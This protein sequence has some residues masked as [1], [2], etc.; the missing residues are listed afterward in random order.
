VNFSPQAQPACMCFWYKTRSFKSTVRSKPILRASLYG[1]R[2]GS[3]P[4]MVS[5]TM[6]RLESFML[7][8]EGEK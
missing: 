3:S 7:K 4:L 1:L 6:R 5:M 2:E 8:A